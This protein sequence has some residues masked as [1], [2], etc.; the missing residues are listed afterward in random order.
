LEESG[1]FFSRLMQRFRSRQE[2]QE[3]GERRNFANHTVIGLH[4]RAGNGEQGDFVRKKRQIA[5]SSVGV[6]S[7]SSIILNISKG[8]I[9]KPPL[10]FI[11]TDTA[12]VVSDFRKALSSKMRVIDY[13]QRRPTN[14]TGVAF[15]QTG[16]SKTL[17]GPECLLQWKNSIMDMMLLAT[18][19]VVIAGRPSSFTQSLPMSVV[20]S[21]HPR[22][23]PKAYCEISI[24][25]NQY[26]CF[27]T[28][29]E[30]CC[31][32]TTKFHLEGIRGYEYSRMPAVNFA[33]G[34]K[35]DHHFHERPASDDMQLVTLSNQKLK[36][37]FLPYDWD[38]IEFGKVRS[39]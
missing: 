16:L 31:R 5:N 32:G 25:A 12:S 29:Y 34:C 39:G 2:V 11:A 22:K 9:E 27:E 33:A 7:L 37:V 30:W 21:R 15:G 18:T 28:M 3:F 13:E 38:W 10:L 36:S 8:W 6:Q 1:I 4:V 23:T 19:D 35:M 26:Q 14:G 20:L 17:E 24:D